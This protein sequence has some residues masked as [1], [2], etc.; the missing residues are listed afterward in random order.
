MY[1]I[2]WCEYDTRQYFRACGKSDY[3][4][5]LESQRDNSIFCFISVIIYTVENLIIGKY[6]IGEKYAIF[7]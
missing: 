7:V 5:I 6:Y 1:A 4:K 2:D 3:Q